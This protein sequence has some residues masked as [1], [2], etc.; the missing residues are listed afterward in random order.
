MNEGF[1]NLTPDCILDAVELAMD[2]SLTGLTAPL[3][4][5]INRVYELQPAAGERL[6]AKFYRPGRWARPTLQDEHDFVADCARDEIPVVAPL[7]LATGG[8]IGEHEGILF[9]VFPKRSGREMELH[10]DEGWRRLGSLVGRIHL[11]GSQ[12]DAANRLQMHPETTTIPEINQLLDGN[13]TAGLKRLARAVERSGESPQLKARI[14]D[15]LEQRKWGTDIDE[16]HRLQ[17]KLVD[18]DIVSQADMVEMNDRLYKGTQR[19]A[20]REK[21]LERYM[22]FGAKE[23]RSLESSLAA[24]ALM[25]FMPG[26]SSLILAGAVRRAVKH[27]LEGTG[28][29]KS[30]ATKLVEEFLLSPEKYLNASLK[31]KTEKQ[32]VVSILT[33]LVGANAAT[34][35]MQEEEEN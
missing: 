5:Y 23:N 31:A 15:S 29:G 1:E 26:G 8:T 35:A 17:Q 10:T 34:K 21:S 16:T 2:L 33:K 6:I 18:S 30:E 24:A 12:R 7:E 25:K 32:A 3:P 20:L 28:R 19:E 9:S 27:Q 22:S 14:R 11:A 4:S 13:D